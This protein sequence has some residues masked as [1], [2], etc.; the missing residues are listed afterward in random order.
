MKNEDI[1]GNVLTWALDADGYHYHF[2]AGE[3]E[4]STY[5][6]GPRVCLANVGKT[7]F[8]ILQGLKITPLGSTICKRSLYWLVATE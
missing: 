8:L 5:R 7:K 1:W 3:I 6:L 2:T 4:P